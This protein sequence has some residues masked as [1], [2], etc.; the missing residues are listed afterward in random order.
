MIQM[1]D[2][3]KRY[4][5]LEVE[6]LKSNRINVDDEHN[7]NN[8]SK[9]NMKNLLISLSLFSQS[10]QRRQLS[11]HLRLANFVVPIIIAPSNYEWASNGMQ[12]H[13]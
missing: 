10:H 4:Y 7:R 13:K 11:I 3:F 9:S 1:I 5:L 12:P 6:P 2:Q 8:L